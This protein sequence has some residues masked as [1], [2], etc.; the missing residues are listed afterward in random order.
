MLAPIQQAIHQFRVN[1]CLKVGCFDIFEVCLHVRA[2]FVHVK[3]DIVAVQ[4][5]VFVDFDI[6]V[7]FTLNWHLTESPSPR[8]QPIVLIGRRALS[9]QDHH[10]QESLQVG[11][12]A[13]IPR[14]L[15]W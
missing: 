10:H 6:D 15:E 8:S 13:N 2:T 7:L 5:A 14:T 4:S 12:V 1:L 9:S 3:K 11:N